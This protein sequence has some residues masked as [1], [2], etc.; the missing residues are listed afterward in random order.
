MK[1][2]E[3]DRVS[4]CDRARGGWG[5]GGEGVE[6]VCS[7]YLRKRERDKEREDGGWMDEWMR[8]AEKYLQSSRYNKYAAK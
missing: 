3:G 5:G 2:K 7:L 1:E 8:E 4:V 6:S